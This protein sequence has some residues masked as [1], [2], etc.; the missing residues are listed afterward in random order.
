MLLV[1]G[2]AM[3]AGSGAVAAPTDQAA[4]SADAARDAEFQAWLSRLVD[5]ISQDRHYS[6]LPLDTD[7]ATSEFTN[8]LHR[9]YRSQI[10]DADFMAW[11]DARYPGHQYEQFTILKALHVRRKFPER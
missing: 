6:R 2:M 7:A 4:L 9:L 3:T 10:T 8:V 11:V 5:A 1:V